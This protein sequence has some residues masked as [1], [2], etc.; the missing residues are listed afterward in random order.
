M[1]K[2]R[3]SGRSVDAKGRSKS[4]APY[5]TLD[6]WI[7]E[8]PAFQELSLAAEHVLMA[9]LKR[10]NGSNNGR[11]SYGCRSGCLSRI[12]G[13][14]TELTPKLSVA[15]QS[16][17]LKE[18]QHQGFIACTQ[19]SSFGQKRLVRDWRLTWLRDD[20]NGGLATREF[21]QPSGERSTI[22]RA[23]NSKASFTE[24]TVGATIVPLVKLS[25]DGKPSI[26]PLQFH[27]RNYGH[28]S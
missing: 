7:V 9:M 20:R 2:R 1:A 18:L 6:F 17:A 4:A 12:N 5:L 10:Y 28:S 8:T 11:I 19:P 14:W 15:A 21:N 26:H 25:P 22:P 16:R 13:A 23:Q 27:M 24:E 3:R